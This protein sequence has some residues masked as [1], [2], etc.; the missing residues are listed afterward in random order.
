MKINKIKKTNK[1]YLLCADG[2]MTKDKYIKSEQNIKKDKYIKNDKFAKILDNAVVG[3]Q[4]KSKRN[5]MMALQLGYD[6]HLCPYLIDK[7]DIIT[8]TITKGDKV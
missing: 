2:H 4:I 8:L 5:T 3:V 1:K 7:G 6:Q